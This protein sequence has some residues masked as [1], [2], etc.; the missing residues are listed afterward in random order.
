MDGDVCCIGGVA[1]VDWS[2]PRLEFSL[3]H[4]I[5]TARRLHGSMVGSREDH[6]DLMRACAVHDITPVIDRSFPWTEIEAALEIQEA[7][8]HF[9][10]IAVNF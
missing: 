2:E 5:P 4:V 9:G 10:K 1:G 3:F 7:G 6:E 8:K